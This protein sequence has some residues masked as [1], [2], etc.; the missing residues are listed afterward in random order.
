MST[1]F[2]VVI[3][4]T[5]LDLNS[6]LNKLLEY[7]IRP[8]DGVKNVTESAVVLMTG[9][10]IANLI[11]AIRN[12]ER[13]NMIALRYGKIGA[14]D[15]A[16]LKFRPHS[17][18]DTF[19]SELFKIAVQPTDDPI[20]GFP[21][22][23]SNQLLRVTLAYTRAPFFELD[24]L[25]TIP[26]TNGNGSGLTT[27]INV[28]DANDESG[29]SPNKIHNYVEMAAADILGS[30]P[31]P[32]HI[33][34]TNSFAATARRFYIGHKAQGDPSNFTHWLEAESATLGTGVASAADADCSNGNKATV[35]NVPATERTLFTWTLTNTQ[36]SYILSQWIRFIARFEDKPNNATCQARLTLLDSATLAVIGRTDWTALNTA[37]VLQSLG[38]L[39]FSRNLQGQTTLGALKLVL[40]AKDS[41]AICDFGLDVL[42]LMPI[43]GGDS[44]RYL[45]PIDE[46]LVAVPAS[47]GVLVDNPIDYAEPF[48][49]GMQDVYSGY[50]GSI[51]LVPNTINRLY[52]MHD[53]GDAS[54]AITRVISVIVKYRPRVLLV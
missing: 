38:T 1:I 40:S 25:T 43:D 30:I 49:E 46:T 42:M 53:G 7:T 37:D 18:A 2:Q 31:T 48:V 51:M 27:G 14:G 52:F 35:T 45:K 23:W 3:G 16:F 34:I 12:L 6:G 15:R 8:G 33:Q 54:A 13:S 11:T 50:G 5:T 32:A 39:I 10:T 24:T 17:A 20:W 21:S 41:A 4:S 47:T 29:S 9:S 36:A 26:L 44:F 28:Y 22:G 19:R